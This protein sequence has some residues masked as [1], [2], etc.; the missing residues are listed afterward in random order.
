MTP[1]FSQSYRIPTQVAALE[2]LRSILPHD[3]TV[4]HQMTLWLLQAKHT[5]AWDNP[6]ATVDA[7]WWLMMQGQ[8]LQASAHM[9][10]PR[11]TLCYKDG[12]E[13]DVFTGTNQT[14][15]ATTLGYCCHHLDEKAL[16]NLHHIRLRKADKQT[17]FAALYAQYV[18]P[19]DQLKAASSG[20]QAFLPIASTTVS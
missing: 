11:I 10:M 16:H 14:Q 18:L 8:P 20:L 13:T 9:A 7:V 4:L 5:Q 3:T 15:A 19:A 1:S 2:A 17:S 12:S 6:Q